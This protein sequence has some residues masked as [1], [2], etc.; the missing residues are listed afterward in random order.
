MNNN[1]NFT[2]EAK[3]GLHEMSIDEIEQVAGAGRVSDLLIQVGTA[4][5]DALELTQGAINS[6]VNLTREAL[7]DLLQ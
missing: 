1:H 7:N 3:T 6:T 5:D 4:A 2:F